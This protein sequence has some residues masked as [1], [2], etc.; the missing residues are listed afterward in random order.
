[1]LGA[2]VTGNS[3]STAYSDHPESES[4]YLRVRDAAQRQHAPVRDCWPRASPGRRSSTSRLRPPG[5]RA[6]RAS[7]S[8]GRRPR[9]PRAA[10]AGGPPGPRDAFDGRRVVAGRD[11]AQRRLGRRR[12]CGATRGPPS[13][14]RSVDGVGADG[15][16]PPSASGR[17]PVSRHA[18]GQGRPGGLAVEGGPDAVALADEGRRQAH[19]P[20]YAFAGIDHLAAQLERPRRGVAAW[21]AGGWPPH[22]V[23]YDELAAD[24]RRRRRRRAGGPRLDAE[25]PAPP[26][27]R[28][29]DELLARVDRA[30]PDASEAEAA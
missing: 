13:R 1:M 11:D 29:G 12:S 15:S 16:T 22:V 25:V 8:R 2:L 20:V 30:L 18:A 7:T 14:P 27:R 5:G 23:V 26:M 10:G 9:R 21:F 19:E 17:R 28:Q 4:A 6:S 3:L 24:P